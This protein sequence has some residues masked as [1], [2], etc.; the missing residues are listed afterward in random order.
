[1]KPF[2]F[3]NESDGFQI[4]LS[5]FTELSYEDDI[6]IGLGLTAHYGD[7]IVKHFVTCNYS[8]RVDHHQNLSQA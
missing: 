2:K 4:L 8:E 5:R 7:N 6:T 1:M 3:T